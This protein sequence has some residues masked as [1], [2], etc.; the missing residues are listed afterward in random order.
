[1]N[2]SHKRI[3]IYI[4]AGA[5]LALSPFILKGLEDF[6][7]VLH[8]DIVYSSPDCQSDLNCV[9][10]HQDWCYATGGITDANEIMQCGDG[11]ET[12]CYFGGAFPICQCPFLK[13]W[14]EGNGCVII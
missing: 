3:I 4:I 6:S 8:R 11:Y 10:Q 12:P 1:M 7:G 2:K 5:V 9:R 14:E 13:H